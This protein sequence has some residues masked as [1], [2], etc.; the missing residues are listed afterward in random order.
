MWLGPAPQQNYDPAFVPFHWRW[1]WDFG[2]GVLADMACHYMD[3]PHWALDLTTPLTVAAK[4]RK[5]KSGDQQ[6]PDLLQVDYTYPAR[7]HQPKVHLTWYNGVS[8]PDLAAKEA[9]HGFANGVLFEGPKG[10]TRRGLR[11]LQAAAGRKV[12]GLHAAEADHCAVHRP[13]QGMDRGDQGQ[14]AR[15]CATLLTAA[16]WPRR[17]CWATWPIDQAGRSHGTTRPGP[18]IRRRRRSIFIG[19]IA[20]DGSCDG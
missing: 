17:S 11:P 12:Q 14:T 13:S 3:L 10:P 6:T 9:F 2:G 7:G 5:I 8:G 1:F 16:P 4:G 18:R 15:R 19:T 20:R